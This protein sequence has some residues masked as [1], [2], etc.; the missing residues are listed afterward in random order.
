MK[1]QPA[2]IGKALSLALVAGLYVATFYSTNNLTLL[3]PASLGLVFA[4]IVGAALIT[5][6][7]VR[8]LLTLL[9]LKRWL[10]VATVFAVCLLLMVLL[11][12]AFIGVDGVDQFFAWFGGKKSVLANA[13]FVVV[14]A[15]GLSLVFKRYPEKLMIIL[16]V[17]T[18]AAVL[19]NAYKIRDSFRGVL[20][21][22][23]TN[24]HY[25]RLTISK[26]PNVYF[27]LTDGYASNAYLRQENIDNN[28]FISFLKQQEF[29]IYD[30]T[31]SN[32]HPTVYALPAILNMEHNYYRLSGESLDFS[33]VNKASRLL[34]AGD[35]NV[36]KIFKRNGYTSQYIHGANYLLLQG[37][38]A[39]YCFPQSNGLGGAKMLFSGIFR[40]NLLSNDDLSLL[41]VPDDEL[42][43]Q[44]KRLNAKPEP[45]PKFQYIHYFSPGHAPGNLIGRCDTAKEKTRYVENL[46]KANRL[47]KDMISA[48]LAK[49]P[50]AVV[51]LAGD[52]GPFIANR[53]HPLKHIER[54]ADYRD[55]VGAFLAVRW[56]SSYTGRFDESIST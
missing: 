10:D 55:R 52:H 26:T 30:D 12:P 53:C 36:T 37:C 11:R 54:L 5:V 39:D 50:D 6:L 8:V 42:V 41:K 1:N 7:A 18:V 16:G 4:V 48:I 13:L 34:I 29:T 46:Y 3:Q 17:M 35:N 45:K 24:Q 15:T 23:G 43:T 33:E 56:P 38:R 22:Q 49:D 25:D 20:V 21:T 2:G 40:M 32:Y 27:I 51:M 31:F 44:I 14:P 47:L 19:L 9:G 28:A